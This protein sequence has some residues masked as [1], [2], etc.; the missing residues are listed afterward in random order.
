TDSKKAPPPPPP[1]GDGGPK[2]KAPPPREGFFDTWWCFNCKAKVSIQATSMS[3]PR[4]GYAPTQDE[5]SVKRSVCGCGKWRPRSAP[6][7]NHGQ[8]AEDRFVAK[9]ATAVPVILNRKEV[10]NRGSGMG[11][12]APL[13]EGSHPST[14]GGAVDIVD[15]SEE[16]VEVEEEEMGIP[17]QTADDVVAPTPTETTAMEVDE[18]EPVSTCIPPTAKVFWDPCKGLSGAERLASTPA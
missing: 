4:I 9:G 6:L 18:L 1:S 5:V 11:L 16:V 12:E 3:T 14:D 7:I 15:E 17:S 2:T 8:A 10:V 13:T